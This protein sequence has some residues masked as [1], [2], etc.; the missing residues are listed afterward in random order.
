MPVQLHWSPEE[1]RAY[2]PK[3]KGCVLNIDVKRF[4]RWSLYYPRP[5]LPRFVTKSW[6][7][8]S[9]LTVQE[10]LV[11][12]LTTAWS[13]HEAETGERCPFTWPSMVLEPDQA[14]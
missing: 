14:A 4:T 10:A 13:W 3:V 7:V 1:A 9:H 6:G 11:F 2:L 8:A 5:T 12:C